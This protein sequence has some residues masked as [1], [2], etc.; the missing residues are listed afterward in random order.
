MAE[1]DDDWILFRL[2]QLKP[3]R[4]EELCFA[5]LKAQGHQDVRHLGAA[6][7]ERGVD[8][9][10]T[11]PDGRR[12]VTQCK[13]HQSLS[14]SDMRP[15]IRTVIKKPMDPPP[16]VYHLVA[17]ANVSRA[18][19]EALLEEARKAPFPLDIASTW[20]ATELVAF[21]RD[22]HPDLR[23]NFISQAS[24]SHVDVV[25]RGKLEGISLLEAGA[26]LTKALKSM[27]GSFEVTQLQ[28]DSEGER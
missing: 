9:S 13:R 18:T 6:G 28:M 20:A 22:D 2:Q 17:T 19:E 27:D 26:Q 21:L 14:P 16:E 12:W 10:S 4:F 24:S 11:G 8:V 7:G 15:E 1:P 3:S 23:E 5:L 25:I